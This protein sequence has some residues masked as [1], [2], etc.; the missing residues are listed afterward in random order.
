MNLATLY[1][2]IFTFGLFPRLVRGY[3]LVGGLSLFEPSSDWF[4][5][6]DTLS[7]MI[8][9]QQD[10]FRR[11]FFRGASALYS[12]PRYEM[13]NNENQ[14][15][16]SMDIGDGMTTNDV[17]VKFDESQR[18]LTVS[19]HT[20]STSDETGYRFNSQFSRSFSVDPFVRVDQLTA[21]VDKGVLTISAPKDV[22]R[23]Q[24]AVR[25]I[26][27]IQ[28]GVDVTPALETKEEPE[29]VEHAIDRNV[30]GTNDSGSDPF[31][32]KERVEKAQKARKEDSMDKP[33]E[34]PIEELLEQDMQKAY[35]TSELRRR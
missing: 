33:P 27:V 17:E 13:V 20:E 6:F 4:D 9:R 18:M 25:S 2:A 19:A 31:H 15:Q 10:A 22:D 5:E 32:V 21:T 11:S 12:S 30:Q 35:K 34:N 24:H 1:F 8:R 23:M 28:A 14:F 3:D 7:S 26:P 29:P 16:V